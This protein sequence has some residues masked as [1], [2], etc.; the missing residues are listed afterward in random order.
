MDEAEFVVPGWR[1]VDDC[2]CRDFEFADFSAAFA[3]MTRVAFCRTIRT[4]SELGQH[5]QQ[6]QYSTDDP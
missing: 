3:F 2:L 6:G 5:I 4:S 1:V